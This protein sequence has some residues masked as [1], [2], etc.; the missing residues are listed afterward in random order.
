MLQLQKRTRF[1][2]YP[3]GTPLS[4]ENQQLGSLGSR[5][6]SS[7]SSLSLRNAYAFLFSREYGKNKEVTL[8]QQIFKT[9]CCTV[10]VIRVIETSHFIFFGFLLGR[11]LTYNCNLWQAQLLFMSRMRKNINVYLHNLRLKF[12]QRTTL[13]ALQ[14]FDNSGNH[15]V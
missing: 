15:L 13:L 5:R 10:H 12:S 6:L 1:I 9:G 11:V 7:K 8:L 2:S 3:L 4:S 14:V